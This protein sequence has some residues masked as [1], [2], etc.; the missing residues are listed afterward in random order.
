MSV[1]EA[2]L[3]I[4]KDASVAVFPRVRQLDSHIRERWPHRTEIVH[5]LGVDMDNLTFDELCGHVDVRIRERRPGY[6][7]TPNVNHV[8]TCQ[9]NE[10]FR[11]AYDNAWL[12]LVDGTPIIWASKLL[13]TPLRQKLS[14]SD[15]VPWLCAWAAQKGHSVYFLGGT[16]GTADETA[17]LLCER[18]PNL[19]VAGVHCPDFGFEKDP[20]Q[21]EDTV[22]RLKD[23]KPDLCFVALGSPKQEYFMRRYSEES[24]VP[25]MIGVGAAFDFVS[26]RIKRAP[27]WLQKSGFEWAWRL[28]QEP[29]RLW[30]RYLVQDSMILKL[31]AVEFM[32][33]LRGAY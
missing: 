9:R 27:Q 11:D 26:G 31:V 4:S 32:Q 24:G 25:V 29:K 22:Q 28:T 19:R 21:L 2:E 1:H 17:R 33:R 3:H 8:C 15:L 23:A 5:L 12:A 30:K 6:I 20:A 14:G 16:P 18:H 10:D 7:V 13:G